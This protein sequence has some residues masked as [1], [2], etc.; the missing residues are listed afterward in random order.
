MCSKRQSI[1]SLSTIEVE[2]HATT[3]TTQEN[4]WLIWLM[5]DLHQMVDCAISLYCDNQSVVHLVENPV[6]HTTKK[7]VEVY[8]Y[9]FIRLK[10]LEEEVDL[11]QIKSE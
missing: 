7:Q 9:H 5:N 1:V 4:A 2:Y 6:F 3:M 8:Y 10:I 11:K